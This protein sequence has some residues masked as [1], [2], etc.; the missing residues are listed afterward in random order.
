LHSGP[1]LPDVQ[2]LA[3][4]LMQKQSI[5]QAVAD[6]VATQCAF[7]H[8]RAGKSA[9]RCSSLPIFASGSD[10]AEATEHD[11][12]AIAE[13]GYA[14]WLLLNR[15]QSSTKPGEG[16]Q[17][18]GG[19]CTPTVLQA[20]HEYPFFGTEQGG[21]LAYL[22]GPEP[23]IGLAL[24]SD[25]SL[26]GTRYSQFIAPAQCN[27]KTGTPDPT[28]QTNSTGGDAFLSIPLPPEWSRPTIWLCNGKTE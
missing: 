1:L 7:L 9:A 16:W 26:Q 14:P 28:G 5:E 18:G 8:W 24:R 20:C 2:K 15:E 21:P 17:T 22:R 3:D 19:R 25:N 11:L 10:V 4:A 13:V 23:I 12:A 6:D 27:M